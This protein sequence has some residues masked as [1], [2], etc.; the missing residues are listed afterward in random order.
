M[1]ADRASMVSTISTLFDLDLAG[2]QVYVSPAT[3]MQHLDSLNT[4]PTMSTP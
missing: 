1:Q 4:L 3:V 2:L